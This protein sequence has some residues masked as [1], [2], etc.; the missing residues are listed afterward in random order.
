MSTCDNLGCLVPM[1][2]QTATLNSRGNHA[3]NKRN[4]ELFGE[5]SLEY[6]E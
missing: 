6:K 1:D 3:E 5:R 2:Y 4:L